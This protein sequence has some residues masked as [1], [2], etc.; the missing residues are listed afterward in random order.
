MLEIIWKIGNLSQL[1][2]REQHCKFSSIFSKTKGLASVC[3]RC[4]SRR[5]SP[6]LLASKLTRILS[7]RDILE[8]I[9]AS[10]TSKIQICWI[11]FCQNLKQIRNGSNLVGSEFIMVY[12][13][14][15]LYWIKTKNVSLKWNATFKTQ[16][17]RKRTKFVS[18][19]NKI[20][21]SLN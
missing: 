20:Q 9:L 7:L 12:Q 13:S 5:K 15:G 8:T 6:L 17:I 1:R 14:L 16:L 10:N 3:P 4:L 18:F 2:I 19:L 21:S 11:T